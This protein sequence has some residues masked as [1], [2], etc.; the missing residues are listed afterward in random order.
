MPDC[1]NRMEK[2]HSGTGE[3]HDFAHTLTHIGFITVYRAFAASAFLLAELA[4]TQ[5]TIGIFKK[6]PASIAHVAVA[7][8][9]TAI[10]GYHYRNGTFLSLYP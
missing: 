9:V 10:D 1:H 7:L 8:F 2:N 3:T 5:T 6:L 4:M